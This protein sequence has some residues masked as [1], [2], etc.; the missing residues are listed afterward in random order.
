MVPSFIP[1]CLRSE[2]QA[3][4]LRLLSGVTA[5][6]RTHVPK[7]EAGRSGVQAHPQLH[8]EFKAG[9]RQRKDRGH[10]SGVTAPCC[11]GLR[12]GFGSLRSM[13]AKIGDPQL[14]QPGLGSVT[15]SASKYKVEN[16]GRRQ[17]LTPICTCSSTHVNTH[18]HTQNDLYGRLTQPWDFELHLEIFFLLLFSRSRDALENLF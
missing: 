4:P 12:A 18:T 7:V 11:R 8:N 2:H 10:G 9:M 3:R 1:P 13:E 5:R 6:P 14:I 16:N 17:P 15:D